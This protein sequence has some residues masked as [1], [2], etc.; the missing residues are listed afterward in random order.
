M[1][2]EGPPLERLLRRLA[3]CPQDFI[4]PKS[5]KISNPVFPPAVIGD[6]F[7][8]VFSVILSKDQLAPFQPQS[9]DAGRNRINLVLIACWLYHDEWFMNYKTSAEPVFQLFG[10]RMEELARIV[11]A[12]QFITD[13]DRREELARLCLDAAG[14]RPKGE[15]EEVAADRLNTLDSVERQRV[16]KAAVEA[17]KREAAI[18][19]A[20]A[21]AEAI[22]A[23]SKMPR[24]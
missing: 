16:I 14:F 8:E 22:E 12:E 15:S 3:E 5:R 13:P 17:E 10:K 20:M 24:E 7:R 6:L 23:A 9:T 21:E 11:K 18:R 1:K 19:K 4:I 2:K